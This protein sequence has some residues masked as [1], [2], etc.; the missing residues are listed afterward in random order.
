[1]LI[2]HVGAFQ[3]VLQYI[4]FVCRYRL[5]KGIMTV[6]CAGMARQ[7][8]PRRHAHMVAIPSKRGGKRRESL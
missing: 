8:Y 6:N 3:V 1:V 4:L 7:S 2:S 5:P